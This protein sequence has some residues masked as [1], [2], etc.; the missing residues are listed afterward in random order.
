[1]VKLWIWEVLRAFRSSELNV[2]I[3]D[4]FDCNIE[5]NMTVVM[6]L[7]TEVIEVAIFLSHGVNLIVL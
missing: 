7:L 4:V 5:S 2:A 6:E 1:M 3:S